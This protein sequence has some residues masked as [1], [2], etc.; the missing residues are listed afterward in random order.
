[1][2]HC[3]GESRAGFNLPDVHLIDTAPSGVKEI[4]A[5]GVVH[6]GVEYPLD[7][8]IYATGFQWMAASTFNMITGRGGVP[9]SEKWRAEGVKTFAGLP[10]AGYPTP[11]TTTGPPGAAGSFNLPEPVATHPASPP[12]R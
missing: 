5:R 11:F 9:L 1:G 2:P 12:S 10:G 7:V 4:N 3:Q 6:D 8:L